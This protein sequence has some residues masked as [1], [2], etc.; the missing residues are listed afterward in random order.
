LLAA[1]ALAGCGGGTTVDQ[2][3]TNVLASLTKE[4]PPGVQ[5]TV[6]DVDCPGYGQMAEL[7]D[8]TRLKCGAFNVDKPAHEPDEQIGAVAV[9]VGEEGDYVFRACTAT[10]SGHGP[11][12]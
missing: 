8:G 4:P 5:G 6:L 12:C 2:V 7:E 3:E 11:K 10:A 1:A 9:T